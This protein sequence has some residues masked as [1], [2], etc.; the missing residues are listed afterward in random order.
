MDA[1]ALTVLIVFIIT[2]ILISSEKLNRTGMSLLGMA[3]VG[4]IFWATNLA[5]P[6]AQPLDFV[7][8]VDGFEWDTILFVTAMMII[9]A[10]AGASGMFQ[11]LALALA[12]PSGGV[13]RS[14]Y[15][16]FLLFVFVISLFLDNVSTTLIMTPLTI[17]VCRALDIDFKPFLISEAIICNVGSIPS[18]VGAVPNIVIA[19]ETGLD[20]GLLFVTFMPLSFILLIVTWF[21]MSR[22]YESTFGIADEH[23]VDSLLDIDPTVMIKSRRDFY[24][25]VIAFAFLVVG[26]ALG[27]SLHIPPV[28]IALLVASGLLILAHDRGVEFLAEV[29]WDTVFFLIGLFGLVGALNITGLIDELGAILQNTIGDNPVAAIIFMIWVP[30]TLSAFLDNLPVSAVLAPIALTLSSVSSILPLVLVFSVG[31][32]GNVFTP[33]GSPSNML[34]I[35]FSERE[36]DPITYREFAVAG[37][38]AGMAHL[39]IGTVYLLLIEFIG[40]WIMAIAGTIIGA[41][42]FM[43]F[44]F[45]YLRSNKNTQLEEIIET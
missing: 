11:Y 27:P 37:T 1:L 33:L 26:F 29:G 17:Q 22:R 8:F 15:T 7:H 44:M 20:A 13:H 32:G 4:V 23:R 31:V 43:I 5:N 38:I 40:L 39:I 35:G 34:A 24:A 6:V 36:H 10:I 19:N 2:Y 3:I 14:L 12:K 18:I 41:I 16:L 45:P 25:S 9:V 42:G 30:A 21:L 28:M